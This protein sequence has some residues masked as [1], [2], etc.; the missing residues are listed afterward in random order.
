M[1]F[2]SRY[3]TRLRRYI[4]QMSRLVLKHFF[5]AYIFA[6]DVLTHWGFV[7]THSNLEL[8]HL[9]LRKYMYWLNI[10]KTS[11]LEKSNL[12]CLLFLLNTHTYKY[13]SMHH[14]IN[15]WNLKDTKNSHYP[16]PLFACIQQLHIIIFVVC[17]QDKIDKVQFRLV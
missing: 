4:V 12:F 2:M 14:F 1:P 5:N 8:I 11:I 17:H 3:T 13:A 16:Q 7:L 6:F 9:V 10:F 15:N